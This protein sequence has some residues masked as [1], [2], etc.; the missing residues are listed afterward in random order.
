MK[1]RLA[2]LGP[3]FCLL[4]LLVLPA[5]AA[6]EA[7][8]VPAATPA[9]PATPAPA[10]T[11][12][13]APGLVTNV[14]FDTDVR[15][16]FSDVS[17]QTGIM[18]IPTEDVR[19]MI[20][21]ELKNMPFEKALRLMCLPGGYVYKQIEEGIWLVG[22]PSPEALAFRSLATTEVVNLQYLTGKE[23]SGRLP[24]IYEQYC[25][26]DELGNQIVVTAPRPILEDTVAMIRGLDQPLKQIMIEA[27]VVET[28]AG[29][30]V[31]F[32]ARLQGRRMGFDTGTGLMTYTGLAKELLADILWLVTKQQA[33]TKA[34]PNIIAQEGRTARVE[35]ATEQYFSV[36][37]GPVSYPYTT[38]EQITA[39]V[40][41]EITPLVAEETGEITVHIKPTVSDAK[42]EGSNKL[43]III[44]RTVDTTL[45][46]KDGEVIAV[47]GLL[48]EVE[49]KAERK[50]P[51]L[52]DIPLIGRLFR[53]TER[54]RQCREIVIFIVP[55]LL[56]DDGTFKGPR[57]L[58]RVSQNGEPPAAFRS[59][60][61]VPEK[62][63]AAPHDRAQLFDYGFA[64][65]P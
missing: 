60:I 47:G 34:N 52:G 4:L 49:S 19:G 65:R 3:A 23:L 37:S 10:A 29:N 55:H 30:M 20:S 53:S 56:G 36:V 26:V 61:T 18:I 42:G 28:L 21:M 25:K 14:F 22:S 17:A 11:S 5:H 44:R 32:A 16:A 57:V 35:V 59:T 48:Q 38:L 2:Y 50:I 43:P 31:E 62:Q 8:P 7:A 9:A 24:G 58:E 51:I 12:P 54:S 63:R 40:G 64:A 1:R 39:T 45:R 41:L 46:V 13:T 33:T 27:L 6:D 15:Q